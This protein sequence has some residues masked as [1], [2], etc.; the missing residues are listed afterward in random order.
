MLKA[1]HEGKQERFQ[2]SLVVFIRLLLILLR[3]GCLFAKERDQT[4]I[5]QEGTDVERLIRE[6]LQR[7]ILKKTRENLGC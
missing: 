5:V 4:Y 6:V 2:E 1:D 3:R 7:E